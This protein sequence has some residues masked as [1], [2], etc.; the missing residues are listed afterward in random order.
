MSK[1]IYRIS[2][3]ASDELLADYDVP[4]GYL[5]VAD[6]EVKARNMIRKGTAN[7]EEDEA[8]KKSAKRTKCE[9]IGSAYPHVP[10]GILAQ[11]F[12]D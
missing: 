3:L 2:L 12:G 7:E 9:E 10:T 8:Y 5:V 11:D 6:T 1:E 4:R